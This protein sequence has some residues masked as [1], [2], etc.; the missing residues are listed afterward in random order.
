MK[1]SMAALVI[2]NSDYPDDNELTNPIHDATDLGARLKSYGFD[3]TVAL[4]CSAKDMDKHLKTFRTLLE[5]NEVA[6]FFFAGHGMQID[7]TNYLIAI[8][9]DMD[10]EDDAKH[11]SLSLD[12]VV[13]AMAKSHSATRIII[14]DACRSNPWERKWHRGPGVRGLASVYAPKGTIIGFATSPGEIAYD[15]TGRNG[16]Y[17]AA[18]LEHI[19]TPDCSI[20]TMFKRVRN[21]VAAASKGKQT[22]WEHTSLSGEFYFNLSLGNLIEEYDGTALADRLFAVDPAKKSHKVI[23]GLRTHDWYQQNPALALLDS[24]SVKKMADNSLFVVGR[25]IYQAACGSANSAIEFVR[26]FMSKTVGYPKEKRKALLDGMLFEIFFDKDGKLR[27]RVKR[28]Y[29]EEIFELQQHDALKDSF[30]FI[31]KALTVAGGDFYAVPGKGHELSVT[32][33]TKKTKDGTIVDAIYIGGTDVLQIK[34]EW[35]SEEV[36]YGSTDPAGLVTN[37]SL[38]SCTFRP[39]Y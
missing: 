8:D 18:L 11:S 23:A 5:T 19:E 1:R 2:G 20:E 7:G 4:N 33:S 34:D 21:T 31:A 27:E 32:V 15:G 39:A 10:T 12:K 6:L 16:T 36:R 26:N 9:T 3:V 25:N 30:E 14:L 38:K 24:N 29:F 37:N 35:A 28:K 22:S 13:D 17:T